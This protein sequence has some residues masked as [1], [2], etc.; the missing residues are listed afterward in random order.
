[1]KK[2]KKV[3]AT[4]IMSLIV[5]IMTADAFDGNVQ[6][7]IPA[8]VHAAM[9]NSSQESYSVSEETF[10]DVE[11]GR[12]YYRPVYWALQND[13]TTGTSATT[14]SPMDDCT[15]A[16]TVTFLWRMAGKPEPESMDTDFTDVVK[17]SFYAK[18]VA[19]AVE[20]RITTGKSPSSFDPDGIC[21]RGEFVTFL[22]RA[23]GTPEIHTQDTRFT[24]VEAGRYYE[25]AVMWAV[26]NG[27]TTG[28][29]PTTFSPSET[30]I[31][32]QVVTFLYR[33]CT[34]INVQDYGAIPYDDVDDTY[35]FNRAI[36]HAMMDKGVE[37][38][39]VP[40]GVYT[41]N[42]EKGIVL[43]SDM[44]LVMDPG[45]VLEVIGNS[46]ENYSVMLLREIQN[47]SISGGQIIG[48]R[49]KHTGSSGEW[50][51]G[52]GIY[53]SSNVS[54]SNVS[55]SAN[56]GD[57]I[58]LGTSNYT[59]EL[60]GCNNI[61]IENCSIFDNRRSNISIVDASHVVIDG[62]IISDANGTAPQC[63]INI[64]PN[65]DENG[66]I[67]EDAICRDISINNTTIN[68]LGKGDYW[69][70]FFCFMTINYPDNSIHTADDIRISSC[71]FNGDC[72][73][74]S[75]T[76]TVISDTVIRGTFYDEQNTR[77]EN[78][79]YESIWKN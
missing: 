33:W 60:Y 61:R 15:R 5:G 42:A 68:V 69:G 35:A 72:G 49:Y 59:D 36:Q 39:Y 26:V 29:S 17:E 22:Y 7:N 75:G 66:H 65:H 16:Q 56:W 2:R 50:G 76:N 71:T 19:W 10:V 34:A 41:I 20:N 51:M 44:N 45:A 55:I 40:A 28:T 4:L 78:V 47:V 11:A 67:P 54:I 1:M 48:E 79:T 63:G 12:Y 18:A 53:D 46:L 52:F 30:C 25:K 62:C 13:I 74:Y 58:Y 6:E 77:L 31:R 8:V 9:F 38:V 32:G 37:T 57:G 21:S 73:N 3:M 14:F 64:E 43:G 70:Q 23:A 27:V 24:D